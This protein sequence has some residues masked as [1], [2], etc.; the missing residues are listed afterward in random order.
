M[1]SG[2]W[3]QEKVSG[4]SQRWLQTSTAPSSNKDVDKLFSLVFNFPI[5]EV[6]VIVSILSTECSVASL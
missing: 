6:E 5:C 2:K 1:G 3:K 4:V